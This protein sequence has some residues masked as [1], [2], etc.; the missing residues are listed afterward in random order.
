MLV[1]IDGAA[2][3]I[4]NLGFAIGTVSWQQ[5][6]YNFYAATELALDDDRIQGSILAPQAR[7]TFV[8]SRLN[9]TLTGAVLAGSGVAWPD[10][11]NGQLPPL[12][13]N[14]AAMSTML[15]V[16][17][18]GFSQDMFNFNTACEEERDDV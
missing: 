18:R 9:G 7:V 4:Q 17:H 13:E 8:K 2:S 5:I 10:P 6:L 16:A 14:I 3:W 11:F 1:N 15:S 12:P